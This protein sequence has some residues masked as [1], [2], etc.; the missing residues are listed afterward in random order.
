MWHSNRSG[1]SSGTRK[2]LDFNEVCLL[3]KDLHTHTYKVSVWMHSLTQT[4]QA[5]LNF[6]IPSII[7]VLIRKYCLCMY[8]IAMILNNFMNEPVNQ[9]IYQ[10]QHS[11]IQIYFCA[12]SVHL[13]HAFLV[14]YFPRSQKDWSRMFPSSNLPLGPVLTLLRNGYRW[15]STLIYRV[16]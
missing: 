11:L 9:F 3:H 10:T 12:Y 2:S 5:I 7:I 8:C 1:A 4:S 13:L 16:N 6:Y 14:V 15:F